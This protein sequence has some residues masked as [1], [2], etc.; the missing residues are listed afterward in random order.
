MN[1]REFTVNRSGN[2]IRYSG[3]NM[4]SIGTVIAENK[5]I[6]V[7]KWS[8]GTHSSGRGMKRTYRP[9]LIHVLQKPLVEGD[10][11]MLLIE[12]ENRKIV[13]RASKESA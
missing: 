10:V 3:V 13:T 11:H 9:S 6:L 5:N 8:G 12:W 7:V 4:D 1:S 2:S